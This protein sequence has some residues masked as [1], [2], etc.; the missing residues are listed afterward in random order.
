MGLQSATG[1]YAH[2]LQL[3]EL[4]LLCASRKVD[5]GQS[6]QFV[7]HDVNVV[8]PDTR[9]QHGDTLAVVCACYR[10]KL[11]ATDVALHRIEVGG[12]RCYTPRVANK[13][14]LASQLLG[15][16]VEVEH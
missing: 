4:R 14:Y 2:H 10:V 13:D 7:H 6:V 16:E 1:A 5:I 12:Y 15:T 3:G 8:A 9:G 11:S